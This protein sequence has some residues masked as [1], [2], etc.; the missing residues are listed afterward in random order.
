[1]TMLSV[2][3]PAYNEENGIAE[4][5]GASWRERDLKKADQR[6]GGAG[7]GR[8]FTRQ[9]STDSRADRQGAVDTT[10]PEPGIWGALK[11]DSHN[12]KERSAF[13]MPTGLPAGVLSAVVS[14]SAGWERVGDRSRMAGADS[15]MPLTRRVGTCFCK[16]ADTDGSA[17][18]IGQRQRDAGVQAGSARAAIPAS[19]WSEPDSGMSTRR[20]R[21]L[22]MSEV[23]IPYSER[24]GA[25]S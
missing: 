13:W 25:R 22:R 9:D 15:E 2:V 11:T 6:A 14:R 18:C 23:A 12:R 10:C 4:I 21:G 1:M 20:S 19:R 24:G 5:A 16:T 8:W 3:I 17:A 7:G